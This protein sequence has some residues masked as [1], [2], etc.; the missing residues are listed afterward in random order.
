MAVITP[1]D[2]EVAFSKTFG[3]KGY[4]EET[5]KEMAALIIS[6][7]G[8]DYAVVDNRLKS[9]ERDTFYKLEEEG[10]VYIKQEEVTL[11]KGKVWRLHYWFL[12]RKKILQLSRGEEEL[13]DEDK[14]AVYIKED[15]IWERK[16]TQN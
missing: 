7:Y 9:R 1:E 11:K 16:S 12:N 2:L 14:Y 5:I 13:T 15:H 4:D 8:F 3:Q 6:L 10:L